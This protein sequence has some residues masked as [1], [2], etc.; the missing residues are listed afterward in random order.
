MFNYK[1]F[2]KNYIDYL[3][4]L[5]NYNFTKDIFIIQNTGYNKVSVKNYLTEMNYNYYG[6]IGINFTRYLIPTIHNIKI[7][8][9]NS[10]LCKNNKCPFIID[11]YIVYIDKHHLNPS[12]VEK[13]YPYFKKELKMKY[14]KQS[15]SSILKEKNYYKSAICCNYKW[16]ERKCM[17][18]GD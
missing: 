18:K 14:E 3:Y 12:F 4:L 8:D 15:K 5:Y 16:R 2:S 7:I 13:L 6:Y 17:P 11:D 10:H 9:L 1:I